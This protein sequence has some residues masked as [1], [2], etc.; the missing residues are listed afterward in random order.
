V[1]SGGISPPVIGLDGAGRLSGGRSSVSLYS[2]TISA[3]VILTVKRP[4]IRKPAAPAAPADA[5]RA[6]SGSRTYGS[7]GA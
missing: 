7:A 6:R 4:H 5:W 1:P 3:Q 2:A